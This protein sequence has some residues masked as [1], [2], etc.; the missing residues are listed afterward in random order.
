MRLEKILA[1]HFTLKQQMVL[2][3]FV[4]N[5]YWNLMINY[6]A[7]RSGK[8]V[9]NNYCFILSLLKVRELAKRN[10]I[11]DPLYI[12]AGT[13]K[14]NIFNNV[15]NPLFNEFGLAPEQ[16][17][18]GNLHL[19]GVT[20][21]LA[22][23]GSV[24]GISGVRGSSAYGAYINEASLANESVFS[25]ILDRCSEGEGRV[26]CDTNPDI[27]THWLKKNYI[28]NAS[29]FIISNHFVLDDNTFLSKRYIENKKATT[30]KGMFYDR[31]VLGLWVT[32]QG[33]V[34]SDFD[35][36]IMLIEHEKIP[37]DLTYFCGVDWG[38]AEGHNGV[39]VVFG[40]D[41]KGNTY[42][43]KEYTAVHKYIDY[44]IDVAHDIQNQYGRN[45]TFWCDSARP[46]YVSM[47]QQANVQATNADK[48]VMTGIESVSKLM[49]TGHFFVNQ[50]GIDQFLDEIYQYVWDS[51]KGVPLKKND[52]VMDAMR[53]AIYNQHKQVENQ[54]IGNIY[55]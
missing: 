13:S 23:T 41:N 33:V 46:E 20:I 47:F 49:T 4:N 48:T 32:G 53:Y 17:S 11:K 2:S 5:H 18:I 15:L 16:D 34:Y 31:S 12:L 50:Q 38:F 51:D 29:P 26:I 22:Y 28:D 40:D 55:L 21:V 8:T 6:G 14:K 24:R 39:I 36:K 1:K 19:F 54:I 35:A 43:I 45:V 42:L 52:D 25:E 9:A 3:Q 44:W 30:P 37:S 7:V 27:P 10:R